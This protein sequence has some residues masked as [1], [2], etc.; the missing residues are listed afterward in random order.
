MSRSYKKNV[1]VKDNTKGMKKVANSVVRHA[2]DV[3]NGKQY[4]KLFQTWD[5]YDWR[6]ICDPSDEWYERIRR[7]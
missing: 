4:R 7:K 5:I 1:F 2:K 3:P 6:W